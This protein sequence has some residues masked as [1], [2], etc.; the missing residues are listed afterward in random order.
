MD[1][2]INERI[3]ELCKQRNWTEYKLAKKSNIRN[4]SINAIF[5]H[6]H[7]PSFHTLSKICDAFQIS[8]SCFFDSEIF[9]ND[10]T[11]TYRKLWDNLDDDERE[12][13]LIYMHG[14]LHKEITKEAFKNDL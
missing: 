8:L 9:L 1:N 6:N 5:K 10:N 13:V 4:S 2:K 14:L 11:L 3:L 7:T 12:K